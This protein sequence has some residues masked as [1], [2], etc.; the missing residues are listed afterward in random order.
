MIE[1]QVQ[2]GVAKSKVETLERAYKCS[3]ET[4]IQMPHVVYKAML[5]G[6]QSQI[7]EIKEEIKEYEDKNKGIDEDIRLKK[8]EEEENG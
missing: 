8:E 7:D 3:K 4:T 6:I 5:A 1:N 2:Y